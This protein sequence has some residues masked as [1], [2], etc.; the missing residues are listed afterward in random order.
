MTARLFS[1]VGTQVR[2]IQGI[3]QT[4]ALG[5]LNAKT[6]QERLNVTLGTFLNLGLQLPG[7]VLSV[8]EM[9]RTYKLLTSV[10]QA[11]AVATTAQATATGGLSMA[12]ILAATTT[13]NWAIADEAHNV[14][15][16]HKITLMTIL[17][18]LKGPVGWAILAA[19]AGVA[20]GAGAAYAQ[21]G[22]QSKPSAQTIASEAVLVRRT[23]GATVHEGE[24]I[25]RGG[26]GGVSVSIGQLVMNPEGLSPG[27]AA[28]ELGW[29]LRHLRPE[30]F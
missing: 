19:G 30:E 8:L 20:I 14:V 15:L 21:V 2:N 27:M 9:V 28:R 11:A 16:A 23:G 1:G 7:I 4:Y 12:Q 26:A 10:S 29:R 18:A 13:G 22:Q 3:Y 24:R 6:E 17:N 5:M 25:S